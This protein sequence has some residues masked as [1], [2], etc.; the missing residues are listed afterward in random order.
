MIFIF[1]TSTYV[2]DFGLFQNILAFVD[3]HIIAVVKP[4]FRCTTI[5]IVKV[6]ILILKGKVITFVVTIKST[7]DTAVL[8][9]QCIGKYRINFTAEK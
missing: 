7:V 2:K 1:L 4:M 5:E 9:V 8:Y 6:T 3:I